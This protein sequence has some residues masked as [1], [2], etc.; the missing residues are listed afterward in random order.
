[1]AYLE[2]H[3]HIMD[4]NVFANHPGNLNQ[5]IIDSRYGTTSPLNISL[6]TSINN[7]VVHV[8]VA[9]STNVNLSGNY[10][11]HIAVVEEHVHFN[12]A[13]GT[14]GLTD[15][16][17]VMKKMLPNAGGTT[18]T[19]ITTIT[20]ITLSRSWTMTNVYDQNEI[21]V[22]AFV[23]NNSTQE[24]LQGAWSNPSYTAP[25]NL[26][27]EVVEVITDAMVCGS[28]L[29]PQVT[30]RNAGNNPLGNATL[31]YSINGGTT[32]NYNWFGNLSTLQTTQVTLPSSNNLVLQSTNTVSVSI[33]NPNG[34][35]DQNNAN[36]TGSTTF[37]QAFA[38]QTNIVNLAL[39]TDNYCEETSWVVRNALGTVLYSGGPYVQNQQAN[40]LFNYSFNL[41]ASGCYEFEILDAFGDGICCSY[42]N[43]SY[44]LTDGNGTL[45]HNGGQFLS[46]ETT[47]FSINP[48]SCPPVTIMTTDP[49]T[50]TSARFDWD[51]VPNAHHYIVRGRRVGANLWTY[52]TIGY[53][54][55]THKDVFGLTTGISY[56]W[57]VQTLCNANGSDASVWSAT[58]SFMAAC[59]IPASTWVNPINTTG[60]Q[61]NWDLVNGAAGY[62][63]KGKRV[64]TTLWHTIMTGSSISHKQIF[65]LSP[66]LTY[67]YTIRSWC[68]QNGNKVSNWHQLTS[69][70][71]ASS[72]RMAT[73]SLQGEFSEFEVS[74][75]PNPFHQ[76]TT[77][78][79]S[80]IPVGELSLALFD[81]AGKEVKRLENITNH[82]IL[83]SAHGLKPGIYFYRAGVD[84]KFLASGKLMVE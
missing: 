5:A 61:I 43:G 56:E 37:A 38:T 70:T 52:L 2:F 27:A 20:P 4:G 10:L 44:T 57:Q 68:D 63:I 11:I 47:P 53:G 81:L 31:S 30:I 26:D 22:I 83:L 69:F 64:G 12:T 40:T 48:I 28:S 9:V 16:Y 8:N 72:N 7:G 24:I 50:P 6:T 60:A 32:V 18:F 76:L 34:G 21:R 74:V 19:S 66:S 79:F 75:S 1:M 3:K 15:F 54:Q 67:E 42:G 13:P 29:S 33:T 25:N 58:E 39:T 62:E 17:N 82:S 59:Q 35:T 46:E 14:N 73:Q 49:I 51:P 84:E 41:G 71:T 36:N 23:Q 80:S 77:I 55:P 65:G 78:K 45:I